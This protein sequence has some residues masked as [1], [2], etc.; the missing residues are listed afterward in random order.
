MKLKP[1]NQFAHQLRIFRIS[2]G[3]LVQKATVILV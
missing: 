2:V 3:V 1:P